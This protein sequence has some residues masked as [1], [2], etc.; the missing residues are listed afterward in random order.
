M[1][2]VEREDAKFYVCPMSLIGGKET[3][4]IGGRCSA[5]RDMIKVE[6]NDLEMGIGYCGVGGEPYSIRSAPPVI[7]K[8]PAPPRA[9][10]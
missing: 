5:W 10:R 9:R 3:M 6:N 8:A 7:T 4:C 1:M 2:Y